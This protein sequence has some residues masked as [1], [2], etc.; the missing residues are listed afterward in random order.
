MQNDEEYGI[1][2]FIKVILIISVLGLLWFL[3]WIMGV[4]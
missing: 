3:M 2:G 1:P 4:T